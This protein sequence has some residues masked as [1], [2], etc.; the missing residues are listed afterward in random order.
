[1]HWNILDQ[2]RKNILPLFSQVGEYEFYLAGGTALALHI[3]HRDSIDFD[4]FTKDPIDTQ[5]LFEKIQEVFSTHNIIK[6]QEEKNT[7]GILID[8]SIK[9][10]FMTY[11]Y[12]LLKPSLVTEYFSIASIPDIAC[13]KC[14]AITGR[15]AMK[16]Y[17]DLYFILQSMSLKELLALCT[18]K[19]PSID[20]NL[21]AK[22]LIY[23]DDL[24]EEQIIYKENHDIRFEEIKNFLKK[25]V[26]GF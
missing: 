12:S 11:S 19:Y 2:H 16:D 20:T 14:S 10:S 1:M 9:I 3:G 23:F 25:Q 18:L 4:F 22:S 21:I 5:K 8:G 7:L 24:E 17:V 26:S 6:I 15:G 13:M